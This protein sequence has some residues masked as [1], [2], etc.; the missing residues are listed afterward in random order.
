MT[1]GLILT[2]WPGALNCAR[3]LSSDPIARLGAWAEDDGNELARI[4]V[5]MCPSGYVEVTGHAI[6][7]TAHGVPHAE[8]S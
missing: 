3:R 6:I 7:T 4:L 5:F 8:I 1:Y 2:S